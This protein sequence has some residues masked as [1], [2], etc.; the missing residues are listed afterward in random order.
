MSTKAAAIISPEPDRKIV[1][2]NFSGNVGK[3]TITTH[4]LAPRIP[5]AQVVSIETIN[6]GGESDVKVRGKAFGQLQEDLQSIN[7]AIID[8]G[9]SNIEDVIKLMAQYQ[10]SHEDF[11]FFIV[12]VVPKEKQQIDTIS[13]IKALAKLG[14]PAQKIRVVF[15]M[16]DPSEEPEHLFSGIRAFHEKEKK[17]TLC[18]DAVM[19]TNEVFAKL[20]ASK[21]TMTEVLND[22]TDYKAQIKTAKSS[23]EKTKYAELL[24]IKRLA[25]GVVTELDSV[26]AALLK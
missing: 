1:V 25:S 9:A 2:L 22:D 16:V 20:K 13:T 10:G 26:F 4:L 3:T 8:V 19:H 24:S 18:M 5:N 17:F 12:P 21:L 7:S 23:E 15:N 11:D 6:S 14:V